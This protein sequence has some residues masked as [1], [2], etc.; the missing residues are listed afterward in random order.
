M[1]INIS[2]LRAVCLVNHHRHRFSLNNFN[3]PAFPVDH[4]I[5]SLITLQAVTNWMERK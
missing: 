3:S 1:P 4:A 2:Q 5:Q